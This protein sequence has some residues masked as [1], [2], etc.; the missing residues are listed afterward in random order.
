MDSTR[1]VRK[2]WSQFSQRG[3]GLK[4]LAKH[5]GFEFGHHD[6]LEDARAATAVLLAALREKGWA[7]DDW[8]TE[9]AR[10]IRVNGST[11]P[12]S[13]SIKGKF[14]PQADGQFSGQGICFTGA[15]PG[16]SRDQA[17]GAAAK[18]GFDIVTTVGKKCNVLVAG[19][20]DPTVLA[21]GASKSSKLL[22]AEARAAKG[23]DILIWS[24][25]DFAGAIANG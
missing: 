1:I 23:E 25:Q 14:E 10:P 12:I 24:P 13:K 5:I 18:L 15:I 8:K 4:N 2:T 3:Y 20:L 19:E 22:K 6:A 21:E 16:M 17:R 9:I 11:G 7:L